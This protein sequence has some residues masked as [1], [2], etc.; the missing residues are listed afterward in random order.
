M[1]V[2]NDDLSIYATRGDIVCLNVSAT[3]DQTGGAYE[4][5]PGDIGRM[6]FYGKKDAENVVL[7]KDFPVVA[8]TDSVGIFLTEADTKI[9]GVISKPTDYWYE[10]ELNPFTNPQTIIGYDEDGAKVFKLFPEGRDLQEAETEPDDI[11]VVDADL[12]M[13]SNRP[14]QNRA[15]ARAVTLLKND[16]ETVDKRLTAKIKENRDTGVELNEKITQNRSAVDQ[17]IAVERARIDQL[18]TSPVAEDAEL[19]DI[20]VGADGNIYDSAGASV[21]SQIKDIK[22]DLISLPV[23]YIKG[24]SSL[25]NLIPHFVNMKK[26]G[27]YVVGNV[28][29]KVSFSSNENYVT[30]RVP[31]VDITQ[32]Y[33]FGGSRFV[34]VTDASDTVLYASETSITQLD[35]SQ[36]PNAHYLYISL[37]PDTEQYIATTNGATYQHA[38]IEWFDMERLLHEDDKPGYKAEYYAVI[39]ANEVKLLNFMNS[40][41]TGF[42][43]SFSADLSDFSTFEMGLYNEGAE[44]GAHI[45]VNNTNVVITNPYGT[46]KE[47]PH[48]LTMAHNIMV[49]IRSKRDAKCDVTVVSNGD[50]FNVETDSLVVVSL[51]EPYVLS[52]TVLQNCKFSF[53]NERICKNVWFFG[54]SYMGFDTVRWMYYLI[55]SPYQDNFLV[56]AYAGERSSYAIQSFRNLC[57]IGKTKFAV[58]CLG[59][60]DG[61]DGDNPSDQWVQMRDSFIQECNK[62]KITPVFATIPSIPT[63]NHEKKNEWIRNSGYQ[64]IDFAN[65]VGATSSGAWYDGFLSSDNVHPSEKGAMAMYAQLISDFP[66][67]KIT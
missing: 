37:P 63:I 45:T 67:V 52:G 17:S 46:S 33:Y 54:D 6:K 36:Y 25:G 20:R 5:Q 28:G 49:N 55:N 24:V 65:A 59:M 29:N 16:L 3:D 40:N 8:K 31:D 2:V 39:D 53:T 22:T 11:P 30:Y 26:D 4:F 27:Y 1:F 14:V 32:V 7:Q 35:M 19:T 58:W 50:S 64:Y 57:D 48:G 61:S 42:N 21:R 13:T 18:I 41:K 9:G 38:K 44:I 23:S 56:D 15:I 10:I 60:N 62:N 43:I 51:W 47:Y 12:D 34:R 66:Q